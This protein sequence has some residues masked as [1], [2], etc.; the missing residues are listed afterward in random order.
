[1][2][3]IFSSPIRLRLAGP[4]LSK[5]FWRSFVFTSLKLLTGLHL[6]REDVELS[7]TVGDHRKEERSSGSTRRRKRLKVLGPIQKRRFPHKGARV[8]H[9]LKFYY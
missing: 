9:A 2:F 1:M 3:F 6:Y 4:F 8:D 7:K 5:A